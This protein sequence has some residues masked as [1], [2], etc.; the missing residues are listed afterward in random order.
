ML[1][2]VVVVVVP[3]KE[4][5]RTHPPNHKIDEDPGW[6]SIDNDLPPRIPN[7]EKKAMLAA[8]RAKQEKEN[9]KSKSM[10][11]SATKSTHS[12]QVKEDKNPEKKKRVA[13]KKPQSD[14]Q[15]GEDLRIYMVPSA[16]SSSRS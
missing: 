10:P 3:G 16:S 15:L 11:G 13:Q 7:H 2:F 6:P 1:Q 5:Q 9:P 8:K 14:G 4:F 12:Q